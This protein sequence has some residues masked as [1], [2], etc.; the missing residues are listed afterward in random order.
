MPSHQ[1]AGRKTHAFVRYGCA[2]KKVSNYPGICRSRNLAGSTRY[3]PGQPH[4]GWPQKG[5]EEC[6][7]YSGGWR[8]V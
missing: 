4:L 5:D 7:Q 6:N 3:V 2:V 1:W 8:L